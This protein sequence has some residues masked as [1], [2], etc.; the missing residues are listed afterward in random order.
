MDSRPEKIKHTFESLSNNNGR[1]GQR[2]HVR[3]DKSAPIKVFAACTFPQKKLLLEI[4]PIKNS[5]LPQSFQKPRIKGLNVILKPCAQLPE[6][7]VKLLLELEQSD[8]VDIFSVF[9]ART[10]DELDKVSHPE[11]AVKA[12]ISLISKWKDFFSGSTDILSQDRQTGL[13]G[14]LYLLQYFVSEGINIGKTI[15]SWTG[16]NKTSQDY[17]FGSIALEVKSSVAVDASKI[18]ISNCR[19]LDDEGLDKLFLA[20]VL[21]DV[22]QGENETLPKLIDIL[23]QNIQEEAPECR[24]DFE[25]K[26]ISAGYQTRHAE[27]YTNR[28]YAKRELNFYQIKNGFPRLLEGALPLGLTKVSYEINLQVCRDFI[29]DSNEVINALRICCD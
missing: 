15:T 9:V 12:I 5:W 6:S 18:N 8:S 20:R 14:E 13:Y 10:C 21:F 4:G 17:E 2:I 16:S 27:L 23:R 29:I 24:L 28:M 7:D 19:Q 22:R 3:I 1:A 26:L 25:E 11:L